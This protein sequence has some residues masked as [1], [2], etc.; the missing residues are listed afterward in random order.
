MKILLVAVAASVLLGT[1]CDPA[2]PDPARSQPDADLQLELG[3][4]ASSDGL[5]ITFDAV[6]GDSR[7]PEGAEC[8]WAGEAHVRLTVD[9][10]A[11]TLLVGDAELAPE[12]V[13]RRGDVML[14]AVALTPYPGSEE[15]E[16]GDTPVVYIDTEVLELREETLLVELGQTKTAASLSVTFSALEYDGRCPADAVCA[17]QGEAPITLIVGSPRDT[18]EAKSRVPGLSDRIRDVMYETDSTSV[19]LT[20]LS[21]YPGTEEAYRGDPPTVHLVLTTVVE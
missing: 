2:S 19:V 16:R 9:G 5:T 7:C 20:D 8:V 17:W 1:G 12:A 15:A 18:V 4:T 11:D 10:T 14:R 21:P 3:E 6:A 13:L